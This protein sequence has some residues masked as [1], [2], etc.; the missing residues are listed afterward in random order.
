M[1]E[2][3]AKYYLHFKSAQNLEQRPQLTK[4]PQKQPPSKINEPTSA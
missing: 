2:I 4:D 3:D 1:I